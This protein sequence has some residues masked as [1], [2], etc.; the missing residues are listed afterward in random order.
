MPFVASIDAGITQNAAG[1]ASLG[2]SLRESASKAMKNPVTFLRSPPCRWLGA[3]Y[4]GTYLAV[5]VT[6]ILRMERQIERAPHLSRLD[7]G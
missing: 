7:R 6:D 5:N 2:Q 3:V 1:T 4:C